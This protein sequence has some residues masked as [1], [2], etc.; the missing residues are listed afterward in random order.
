MEKQKISIFVTKRVVRKT[1]R[2]IIETL[3]Y[4]EVVWFR[5]MIGVYYSGSF[6]NTAVLFMNTWQLLEV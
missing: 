5:L 3:T 2:I 4:E 6:C 1:H